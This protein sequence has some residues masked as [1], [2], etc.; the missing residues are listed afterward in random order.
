MANPGNGADKLVETAVAAGIEF[1]L[2]NPGT[3]EMLLVDA[4]DRVPGMRGVLAPV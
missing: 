1:C 2:T 3:T 4:L